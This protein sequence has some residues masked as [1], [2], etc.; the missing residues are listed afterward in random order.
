[1]EIYN[2]VIRDLLNPTDKQLKIR[3][4]PKLGIY[5]EHLA[6]L[7]VNSPEE[8]SALLEQG[9]K[10][11]QVAATNMNDRSCKYLNCNVRLWL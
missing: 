9:N 6:E 11:K 2:E 8:I 1:M 4:H 5:V 3:E 10:V 7:V